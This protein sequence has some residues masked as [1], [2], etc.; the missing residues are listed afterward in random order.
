MSHWPLALQGFCTFSSLYL[1]CSFPYGRVGHTFTSFRPLFSCQVLTEVHP[2]QSTP[3]LRTLLCSL[4]VLLICSIFLH[5]S[6]LSLAY[7]LLFIYHWYPSL[8]CKLHRGKLGTTHHVSLVPKWC[9]EWV[10]SNI[11]WI[12][13]TILEIFP[14]RKLLWS[15]SLWLKTNNLRRAIRWNGNE[16]WL[17]EKRTNSI[18]GC[19]SRVALGKS[20]HLPGTQFPHY[21]MRGIDN[22]IFKNSFSL[23]DFSDFDLICPIWKKTILHCSFLAMFS[24][25]EK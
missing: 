21:K 20:P 6:Y 24:V 2:E 3:N 14:P 4:S 25:G 9:S 12:R 11:Y 23:W 8:K 1:E 16:T 18:F 22:M 19:T 7:M 15:H 17:R 10:F 5:S 13:E